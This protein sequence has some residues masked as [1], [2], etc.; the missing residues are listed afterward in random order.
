MVNA[1]EL[2]KEVIL[3]L[4][5][6]SLTGKEELVIE[7]YKGIVEYSD[8]IIRV[9]TAVGVLRVGGKGLLLKQLT[10]ECIVITG[11]IQNITFL[12]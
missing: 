6:I 2:P 11:S 9:S 1:L 4:P 10:S 8:E 12:T 3:N 7:N 5:L